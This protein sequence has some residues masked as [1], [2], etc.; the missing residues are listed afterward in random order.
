MLC[1]LLKFYL[2]TPPVGKTVER[3][4]VEWSVKHMEMRNHTPISSMFTILA[5]AWRDSSK[6]PETWGRFA[7]L[8]FKI[9]TPDLPDTTKKGLSCFIYRTTEHVSFELCVNKVRWNDSVQFKCRIL[10]VSTTTMAGV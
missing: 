10:S 8:E 2:T 1:F 6:L 9:R 4:M 7:G 3:S 5:F